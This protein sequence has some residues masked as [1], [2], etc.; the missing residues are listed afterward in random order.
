MNEIS[1]SFNIFYNLALLSK[2][3]EVTFICILNVHL[4]ICMFVCLEVMR[5]GLFITFYSNPVLRK[6]V[7]DIF[8]CWVSLGAPVTISLIEL[9]FI[10]IF[11]MII[12]T[13]IGIFMAIYYFLNNTLGFL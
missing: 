8:R 3:I 1:N 10:M 6:A 4:S 12:V 9:Y 2:E 7:W 13:I 5:S 11:I